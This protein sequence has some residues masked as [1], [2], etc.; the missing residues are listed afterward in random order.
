MAALQKVL[1]A[2]QGAGGASCCGMSGQGR[3]ADH[4][5]ITTS[6]P[7]PWGLRSKKICPLCKSRLRPLSRNERS[8]AR[9]VWQGPA[10]RL[11]L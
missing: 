11:A 4:L 7:R 5:A 6:M 1:P 3:L 9:T 2:V 8:K 10:E